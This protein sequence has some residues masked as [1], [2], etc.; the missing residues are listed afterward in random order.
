M[1]ALERVCVRGKMLVLRALWLCRF[2]VSL[3]VFLENPYL[4][5][6]WLDSKVRKRG[7]L[8]IHFLISRMSW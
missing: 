1:G 5:I 4:W 6:H 3:F 2:S 7:R 8:Y